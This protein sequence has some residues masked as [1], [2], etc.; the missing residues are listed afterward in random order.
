M[1]SS[2]KQCAYLF[3]NGGFLTGIVD[4]EVMRQALTAFLRILNMLHSV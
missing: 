4:V 3:R 2:I 1:N